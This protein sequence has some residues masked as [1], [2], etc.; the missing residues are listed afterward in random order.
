MMEVQLETAEFLIFV[1]WN[2]VTTKFFRNS[3]GGLT[4]TRDE[5]PETFQTNKTSSVNLFPY[6]RPML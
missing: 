2:V 4:T 6:C 3:I 1:E 5:V